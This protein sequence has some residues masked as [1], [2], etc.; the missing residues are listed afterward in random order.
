MVSRLT[1]AVHSPTRYIQLACLHEFYST[2]NW[3]NWG[4]DDFDTTT[5]SHTSLLTAVKAAPELALEMLSLKLG[6]D[7]PMWESKM[8]SL[9]AIR[10]HEV[11]L[12]RRG[13]YERC[14]ATDRVLKRRRSEAVLAE[15]EA[16]PCP[17]VPAD[18]SVYLPHV[19]MLKV[20]DVSQVGRREPGVIAAPT[21]ATEREV[22]GASSTKGNQMFSSQKVQSQK[23]DEANPVRQSSRPRARTA[24]ARGQS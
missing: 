7:W 15:D 14:A 19:K 12:V 1:I 21:T 13:E 24:R 4:I 3:T 20:D 10:P 2:P 11:S 17:T 18:R 6:L 23:S 9:D 5:L 16:P 8:Q 22:L